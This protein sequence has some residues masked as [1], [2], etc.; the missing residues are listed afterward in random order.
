NRGRFGPGTPEGDRLLAHELAHV[1]QQ[2]G[3]DAGHVQADL[4]MSL[5]TALG[6]FEISMATRTTPRVG[7]EGDI[8]FLPDSTGPYS[9]QIGLVQVVNVTDVGGAT[10]TPGAPLD[11]RRD[12]VGAQGGRM[13]LMT[14]G[15][16]TAAAG[17]FVDSDTAGHP[18]G[19]S[20]GPNYIEHW[21]APQNQFGFLRSPTDLQPAVLYDYPSTPHPD[22]DFDFETVA[23]GADTQTVYG[24][25]NWGFQIRSHAVT[26][27]Y[28]FALDAQSATFE[29]A[30]ERFRGFYTHEPVVIYFDTDRDV[31]LPGEAAKLADI[32]SYMARYPDVRVSITGYADERG[33]LGHNVDLSLRRAESVERMLLGMGIAASNLEPLLGMGPTTGF[34]PGAAGNAGTWLANRRVEVTFERTASTP[35]VP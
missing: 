6:A 21:S 3:S 25:L 35:I 13:D 11:W 24:A 17:W 23:K 9:A 14:Q 32:P 7:M 1:V 4:M 10:T 27:E 12:G 18:Q 19:S 15:T 22:I 26:H 28:A 16:G 29:E 34:A 20:V 5:P 8:R 31:P 2:G 30:L 33:N